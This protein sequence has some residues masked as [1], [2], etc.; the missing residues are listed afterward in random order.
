MIQVSIDEEALKTLYLEKVEERLKEL[1]STVFFMNSKQLQA[2][3]G[4]SW[5]TITTCLMADE[6]FP[7]IRLGAKWLF[8]TKEVSDYMKIYYERVRDNGGD[9]LKYRRP[10][11]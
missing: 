10:G 1:E 2:Y 7:K 11:Q 4:M 6:D 8:P 3:L 5:N 9:I